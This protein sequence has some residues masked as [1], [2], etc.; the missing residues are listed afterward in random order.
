MQVNNNPVQ[1]GIIVKQV[2][3]SQT[4][5]VSNNETDIIII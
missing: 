5:I 2:I 3:N 4:D 1:Q